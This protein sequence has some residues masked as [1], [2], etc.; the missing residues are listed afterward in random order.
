MLCGASIH[1][2]FALENRGRPANGRYMDKKK[3]DLFRKM[4]GS[5]QWS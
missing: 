3:G 2:A 4:G 5:A 1:L